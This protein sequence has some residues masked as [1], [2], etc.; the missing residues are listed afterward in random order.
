MTTSESVTATTGSGDAPREP[1]GVP[2][3]VTCR[4]SVAVVVDEG[5]RGGV[6]ETGLGLD[7]TAADALGVTEAAREVE[8][9]TD[10][11]PLVLTLVDRVTDG[12]G[13]TVPLRLAVREAEAEA[14]A[15]SE[16]DLLP[17]WE[18]E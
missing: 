16:P 18:R 6:P 15:D 5:V 13:M 3:A 14:E 2:V 10:G 11:V 4:C 8:P 7:V 12:G 17:D 9:L 1:V